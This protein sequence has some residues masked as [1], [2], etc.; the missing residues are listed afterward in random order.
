MLCIHASPWQ[1]RIY[2]HAGLREAVFYQPKSGEEKGK[3]LFSLVVRPPTGTSSRAGAG[4][5]HPMP[6]VP[7]QL[8]PI[9]CAGMGI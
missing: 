4:E 1:V 6:K 2:Y 8:G 7:L 5:L 3:F 9:S